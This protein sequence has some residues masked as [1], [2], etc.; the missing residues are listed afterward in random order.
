MGSYLGQPPK[1]MNNSATLFRRS[2]ED[3]LVR[4]YGE[5]D[6]LSKEILTGK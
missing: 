5:P 4:E 3:E 1:A 2:D 6:E